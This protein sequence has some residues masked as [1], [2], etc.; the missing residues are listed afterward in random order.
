MWARA[1]ETVAGGA[2]SSRRARGRYRG[3]LVLR[4]SWMA[5]RLAFGGVRMGRE[6]DV[7]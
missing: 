7:P 1:G 5:K 2:V 6:G 4:A 3:V